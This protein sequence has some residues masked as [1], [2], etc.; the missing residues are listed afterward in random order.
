MKKRVTGCPLSIAAAVAISCLTFS[1]F[2]ESL[3]LASDDPP[4]DQAADYSYNLR[5][6]VTGQ[7]GVVGFRL[8]LA[9]YLNSRS[10]DLSDLRVFDAAGGKPPFALYLPRPQNH[11]QIQSWPVKQFPVTASGQQSK[12]VDEIELDIQTG[13]DGSLLSVKTKSAK[14]RPLGNNQA[15]AGLVLDLGQ[16]KQPDKPDVKPLISALRF[17]LP[18]G[19]QPYSAQVWLEASDNL[20]QWETIAAAEL[21]W[22]VDTQTAE[23][24]VNDRLDF[25]PR[26]FRYARLSWRSGEPLRFAGIT[27]ESAE[28]TAETPK[29]DSLLLQPDTGRK[30]DDL[31][32][33]AGIAIP[34][35]KID[36]HFTEP[37]IVLPAQV[38]TYRE[39][40]S[41]QLGKPNEWMFVPLIRNVFYRITQSGQP[42]HSAPVSVPATHYAE[43][44][45]RPQTPTKS[46]PELGLLWQPATLVFLA[47]GNPPYTLAF[48]REDAKSAAADL[49]Q[50]APGFSVQELM[51]L[52]QAQAGSLQSQPK[53]TESDRLANSARISAQTRTIVLWGILL[54]GVAVLG[55]IA[56]RLFKQIKLT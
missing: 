4:S 19:K 32:Y 6:T 22:L 5:L 35:E 53:A 8:P 2:T 55:T 14:G 11:T 20:K 43:W 33:H 36:L 18:P 10:A 45:V 24:L 52:E 1:A 13:T 39:L 56:W 38:G 44:V 50:V 7:Q 9:V 47:S 12:P 37:N 34:V 42:R 54:L 48:G 17:A 28:Q 15:L 49:S 51:Q 41:K 25:A 21:N 46:K 3:A 30:A 29:L 16:P 27:A 26:A 40:P 31:L 23:T